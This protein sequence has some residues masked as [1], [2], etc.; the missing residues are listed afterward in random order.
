MIKKFEKFEESSDRKIWT[1]IPFYSDGREINENEIK[2]FDSFIKAEQYY[3]S[4][5]VNALFVPNILH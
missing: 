2:S 4:L 3:N 1:V 5:R